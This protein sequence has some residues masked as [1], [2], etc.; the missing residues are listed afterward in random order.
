MITTAQRTGFL[1]ILLVRGQKLNV[2]RKITLR[3]L[4]FVGIDEG[5]KSSDHLGNENEIQN[6]ETAR[7]AGLDN[8]ENNAV[9]KQDN[10]LTLRF[11]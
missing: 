2:A 11:I 8:G 6:V 5:S 3:R 10:T 4:W 1:I 7:T 9:E